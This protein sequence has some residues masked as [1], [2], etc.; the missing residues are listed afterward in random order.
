MVYQFLL[1]PAIVLG[2]W[3]FLALFFQTVG[4]KMVSHYSLTFSFLWLALLR[5]SL[6]M[7]KLTNFKCRILWVLTNM[8]NQV[9]T[10]TIMLQNNSHHLKKFPRAP[11]HSI[12]Y[13]YLFPGC[14]HT[15]VL[16]IT[17]TLP[18][19]DVYTIEVL[20]YIV[21]CVNLL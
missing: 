15:N 19:L 6:H 16:S 4:C 21:F 11:S 8:C 17:V 12:S 13:P 5:Y 9:A 10:T 2:P 18:F 1:L 7:T 3:H 14:W 20:Q